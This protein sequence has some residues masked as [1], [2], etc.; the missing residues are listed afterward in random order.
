MGP[1][2]I[3]LCG[4]AASARWTERAL[5]S[6]HS[7][8]PGFAKRSRAICGLDAAWAKQVHGRTVVIV[9][10]PG[11]TGRE[12]DALVT[13]QKGMALMVRTADCAPIALAAPEGVVAVAHGGWRGLVAGVLQS[14]AEAMRALGAS[15]IHAGVG[16]CIR[17]GCYE[18]GSTDLDEVARSLGESVRAETLDGRPAL[19][20]PAAVRAAAQQAGVELVYESA[21][22]TACAA[23]RFWSHRARGDAE[24]Q[25]VLAWLS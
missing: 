2:Q 7:A 17:S 25:G 14:T 10:E 11:D 21:D 6:L 20:L 4:G 23:D 12:A 24:R 15:R 13:A 19:D 1:Q 18:F 22:C 5:G 8:A 3:Q 9:T 16:P